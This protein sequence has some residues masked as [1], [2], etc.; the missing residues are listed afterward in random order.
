SALLA[1]LA[2]RGLLGRTLVVVLTEFGRAPQIGKTFQNSGGPAG[3]DHWSSCFSV[4]LA[5]GGVRG[6][7]TYGR[8]AARGGQPAERPAGPPSTTPS[9]WIPGRRFTTTRAGPTACAKGPLSTNCWRIAPPDR[10]S[11]ERR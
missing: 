3:R 5:G 8:S 1:D 6:G 11:N 9:A 10:R 2:D 7:Q 4:L